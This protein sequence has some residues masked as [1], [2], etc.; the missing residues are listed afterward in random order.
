MKVRLKRSKL[1]RLLRYFC[2]QTHV[3]Y[4]HVFT[5]FLCNTCCNTSMSFFE[6][7]NFFSYTLYLSVCLSVVSVSCLLLSGCLSVCLSVFLSSLSLCLS[8]FFLTGYLSLFFLSTLFLSLS[9]D[10]SFYFITTIDNLD[11]TV[12]FSRDL[13]TH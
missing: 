11:M 13:F 4:L 2:G 12:L 9:F 5:G 1:I 6:K 3:P 8:L 7:M 10:L